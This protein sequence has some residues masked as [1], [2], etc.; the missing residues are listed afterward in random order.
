MVDRRQLRRLIDCATESDDPDAAERYRKLRSRVG[1]VW[2]C[3]DR[4]T[5]SNRYLYRLHR[6][7]GM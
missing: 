2:T 3:P 1:G 7:T 4:V 6:V 5:S